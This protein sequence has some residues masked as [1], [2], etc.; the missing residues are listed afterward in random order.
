MYS[1]AD[2]VRQLQIQLAQLDPSRADLATSSS[3]QALLL[4][5]DQPLRLS[6]SAEM[7]AQMH[8]AF[9]HYLHGPEGA[10]RHQALLAGDLAG[11][12]GHQKARREEVQRHAFLWSEWGQRLMG[13]L[14]PFFS[15]VEL[16]QQTMQVARE[17]EEVERRALLSFH[18]A[19]LQHYQ[20]QFEIWRKAERVR[21]ELVMIKG[22]LLQLIHDVRVLVNGF[23]LSEEGR[24][25]MGKLLLEQFVIPRL[26]QELGV[27]EV[28]RGAA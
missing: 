12:E 25:Q 5:Q 27:Q 20:D 19:K 15:S 21:Q 24:E 23:E 22:V 8:E 9:L 14:V 10:P 3:P 6:P 11:L 16:R 18:E 4:A 2:L 28:E 17:L 13:F 1:S 7:M 26:L